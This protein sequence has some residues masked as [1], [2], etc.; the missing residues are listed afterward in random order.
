MADSMIYTCDE[1]G[2]TTTPC[3]HKASPV[4]AEELGKAI[5]EAAGGKLYQSWGEEYSPD[6]IAR[7]ILSRF[8]VTRK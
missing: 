2:L 1:C 6:E 4:T 8:T 5:D 7:A 3:K